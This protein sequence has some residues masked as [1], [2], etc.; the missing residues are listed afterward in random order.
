VP[1]HVLGKKLRGHRSRRRLHRA[2]GVHQ[3]SSDP[4]WHRKAPG[5]VSESHLRPPEIKLY[6]HDIAAQWE[7]VRDFIIL[8]YKAT[9][10]DDTTFWRR[11]RDMPIPQSLQEKIELFRSSGRA[12]PAAEELFTDHSWIAM[13]LRQGIT[14]LG[15]DPLADSL[16]PQNVRGF[17]LH[18]R[19]VTA[20]TAAAM[21]ARAAFIDEHC[22]PRA[23]S[24]VD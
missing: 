21:P 2:P 16:P 17:L 24:S 1:A 3:H 9:E 18:V 20:K 19:D 11:C 14:P 4:D 6:N 12:L 10:R 7:W 8:H 13:M 5:A 15:Y 23:L 22:R